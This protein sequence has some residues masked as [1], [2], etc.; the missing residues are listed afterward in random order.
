MAEQGRQRTLDANQ[1]EP[2]VAWLKVALDTHTL[3]LAGAELLG[4]GAVQ[5][6]WRLDVETAEG[7]RSGR[8]SWVLRTDAAARLSVSLDRLAEAYA[9]GLAYEV[10]VKVPEPIARCEDASVIGAPFVVQSFVEGDAHGLR[11]VRDPGIADWGD[12][13]AGELGLEL[14]RI[15]SVHPSN[16]SADR[17]PRPDGP[18]GRA[19]VAKLRRALTKSGEP[20]PALEYV[21]VW[22]ERNAPPVPEVLSLVHGDFRTGNYLVSDGRLAGILDWEFA[23]WGDPDEDL[24]WL[25]AA[26]WRFGCTDRPVGGIAQRAPLYEAYAR[27]AGRAV[28][29][30]RVHYW[31]IMAAARWA[32]VAVLQGDRYRIGGEDS[33]ELALTGLMPSELELEALDG[34]AAYERKWT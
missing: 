26:C 9:V 27:A 11:L 10:G 15:H 19:E 2:L 21:L 5:E 33:I 3:T 25:C 1:L 34:L 8:H 16:E 6:N 30:K 32:G 29:P 18:P 12:R 13:L 14:A 23:H 17:L 28:D 22:L 7:P 20:R 24:G 4:G 31:E